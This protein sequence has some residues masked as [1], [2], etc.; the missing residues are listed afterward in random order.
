MDRAPLGGRPLLRESLAEVYDAFETPRAH[1]GD[2]PFLRPAAAR[3]YLEEV[4]EHALDVIAA[5]G[6]GD[7]FIAEMVAPP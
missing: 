6:I 7:G 4:R 1:R 5:R 3:E 2:L